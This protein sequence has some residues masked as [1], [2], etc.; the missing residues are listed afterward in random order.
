[1][2]SIIDVSIFRFDLRYNEIANDPGAQIERRGEAGPVSAL[3]GGENSPAASSANHGHF[4]P[5]P[6]PVRPELIEK[7]IAEGKDLIHCLD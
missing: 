3:L 5:R 7:P 1:M 4:R 2:N 6:S